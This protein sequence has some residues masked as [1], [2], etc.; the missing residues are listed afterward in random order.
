MA[1]FSLSSPVP[2]TYAVHVSGWM[3]II[4]HPER[5]RFLQEE[6]FPRKVKATAAEAIEHARRVIHYRQIR[7][8]EKRRRLEAICHPRY[9]MLEAA[10]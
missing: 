8:A 2:A 6:R 5:P 3:P 10:E 1:T 7:A 4:R 9:F